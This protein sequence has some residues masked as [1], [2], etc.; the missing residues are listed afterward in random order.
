MYINIYIFSFVLQEEPSPHKV[1][2]ACTQDLAEL[3]D[4]LGQ[5]GMQNDGLRR[6]RA[7][8]DDLRQPR[9]TWRDLG[10]PR[11][12]WRDLRRPG[13]TKD[14]LAWPAPPG[15]TWNDLGPPGTTLDKPWGPKTIY[16]GLGRSEATY[17]DLRRHKQN[18]GTN[19]RRNP[20]Q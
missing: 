15:A 20:K 5:P 3:W 8:W 19:L 4:E 10:R 6:T 13:V 17:K 12:I 18:L 16:D 1:L 9:A 2:H 7:T 11:M 14:E